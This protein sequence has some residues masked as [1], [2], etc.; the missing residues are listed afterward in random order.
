MKLPLRKMLGIYL[1]AICV[2]Q[3][4]IYSLASLSDQLTFLF[5]FDPRIGLFFLETVLRR[6]EHFPGI[7]NWVSAVVILVTGVAQLRYDWL[8]P[9]YFIVE[10]LMSGPTLIMI[11]AVAAVGLT[12]SHGFSVGELLIPIVVFAFAT[13]LPVGIAVREHFAGRGAIV[14]GYI[15]K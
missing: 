2:I 4:V 11:L 1:I 14:S 12:P 13:V 7:L 9:V 8:L 5:Y 10:I 6:V 15:P 3:I